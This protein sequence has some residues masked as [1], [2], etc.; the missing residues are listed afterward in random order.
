[1]RN[2]CVKICC[3]ILTNLGGFHNFQKFSRF[4]QNM[5]LTKFSKEL[6]TIHIAFLPCIWHIIIKKNHKIKYQSQ[7]ANKFTNEKLFNNSNNNPYLV[8][9]IKEM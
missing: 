9:S 2:E 4:S 3:E 5:R 1:M 6:A 8:F 7:K